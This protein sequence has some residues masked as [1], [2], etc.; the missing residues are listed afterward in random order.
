MNERDRQADLSGTREVPPVLAFDPQALETWLRPHITGFEGPVR[1]RQFKGGQSNPTYE[2]TTPAAVYALR[3]K[4]PGKLLQSAHAVDREFRVLTALHAQGFPVP[5]PFVYCDDPHVIGTPFYV[6]ARVEGR[7][8]WDLGMPQSNPAER[9]TI[10]D[11]MNATIARLHSLDPAAIGLADF[12]R[13]EGYVARQVKRWSQQY[14][15]SETEPVPEMD[16]LIAWLP[17]QVPATA[18]PAV[19]HGDYRLDNVILHPEEPRIV[20]V[21]DWELAT[22]GD[23]Y[24]DFVYHLMSWVMPPIKGG[25]AGSLIGRDLAALGIPSMEDYASNYARRIGISEIPHLEVLMAYNFFRIAA[26]LQGI[27]GRVR[28][29]TASS[30]HAMRAAAEVRPVAAEGWRWAQKAGAV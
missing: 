10:Y 15:A 11:D 4:P 28:D 13:P 29:G 18:R 17:D 16:R 23:P 19:V 14:R 27:V 22:L 2:I 9:A 24:A 30:E 20:A 6:M 12:G 25:G 21:I 1:V 8:Y 26:I 7:V 3:R 5:R